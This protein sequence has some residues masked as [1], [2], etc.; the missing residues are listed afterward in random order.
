MNQVWIVVCS[1]VCNK[2]YSTS[3]ITSVLV[4]GMKNIAVKTKII[5]YLDLVQ[6]G[7]VAISARHF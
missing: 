7:P 6:H 3:S 1:V 2:K 4:A 5:H